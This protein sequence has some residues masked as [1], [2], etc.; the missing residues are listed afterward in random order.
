[1]HYREDLQSMHGFRCYDSIAP[2]AE[3]HR[4]FVLVQC[5]VVNSLVASLNARIG[6]CEVA[7][8]VDVGPTE[9]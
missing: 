2:N 1:M 9:G 4:V 5:M 3:C 8:F 7:V 6:M